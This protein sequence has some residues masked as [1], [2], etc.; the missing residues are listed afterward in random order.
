MVTWLIQTS[1]GFHY[2]H[3]DTSFSSIDHKMSTSNTD[4]WQMMQSEKLQIIKITEGEMYYYKASS[5]QMPVIDPI[6]HCT[7]ILR[8]F[9]LE[10]VIHPYWSLYRARSILRWLFSCGLHSNLLSKY[11]RVI[12][13]HLQLFNLL[14]P[15]TKEQR[16]KKAIKN[17]TVRKKGDCSLSGRSLSSSLKSHCAK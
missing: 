4:L 8:S 12:F 6:D 13:Y 2:L 3:V 10:Q 17:A 11:P 5:P 1:V 9:K 7:M 16:G 15:R 14:Q